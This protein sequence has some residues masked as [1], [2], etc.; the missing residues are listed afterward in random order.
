MLLMGRSSHQSMPID[1]FKR[2]KSH[3]FFT[4]KSPAN[5]SVTLD[6]NDA[7]SLPISIK[8][9][10]IVCIC[11]D[12]QASIPKL[13]ESVFSG[14]NCSNPIELPLCLKFIAWVVH[15]NRVGDAFSIRDGHLD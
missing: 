8:T 3:V 13:V 11:C 1:Y 9:P 5:L 6:H 15:L 12:D 7:S 14:P 4:P 10:A 2:V